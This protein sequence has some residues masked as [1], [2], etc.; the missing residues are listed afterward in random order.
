MKNKFVF[1][2]TT[3]AIATLLFTACSKLPQAEIDQAN[4]AIDSARIA[5]ADVYVPEA[6]LGLQDSMKAVTEDIEAQKSKLFKN[7][8]TSKE[9]LVQVTQLAKEVALQSEARKVEV[10]NEVETGL[11]E[12][13]TLVVENKKLLSQAP[14]GK[15]GATAHEAMKNEIATVEASVAEAAALRDKGDLMAA[16]DKVKA[17][18]EQATALNTELKEIIAKYKGGR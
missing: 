18:K 7:Y 2:L 13:T 8:G 5:G 16:L 11:T 10:K 17:A 1:G 4:Q 12:I 6:F 15:E 9:K 3:V 14:K